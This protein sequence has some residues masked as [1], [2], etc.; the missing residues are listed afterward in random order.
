MLDHTDNGAAKSVPALSIER[1]K[2]IRESMKDNTV[3]NK[4][5][6]RKSMLERARRLSQQK[7]TDRDF[8]SSTAGPPRSDDL[9]PRADGQDA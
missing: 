4:Q 6:T 8:H 3:R 7:A 9:K 2:E 1:E 5:E